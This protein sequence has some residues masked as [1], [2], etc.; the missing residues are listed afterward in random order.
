MQLARIHSSTMQGAIHLSSL[1]Q[2]DEPS[3]MH[4]YL[5]S[6]SALR[7]IV[8]MRIRSIVVTNSEDVLAH[9]AAGP[10]MNL[11]ARMQKTSARQ[12]AGL[13]LI[14][15]P[16]RQA[17]ELAIPG[18][19][20]ARH[21]ACAW[22]GCVRRL[23]GQKGPIVPRHYQPLNSRHAATIAERAHCMRRAPSDSEQVLWVAL[24]ARKLGIG[25]RR[26]YVV[27]KFIA[28]F[29]A[30]SRKVIV[31]VD[32]GYHRNRTKPDAARDEKLR[33]LG[34]QVLRFPAHQVLGD[35]PRVVE[36]IRAA[37]IAP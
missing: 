30:P 37:L 14:A 27:G 22:V 32:G 9:S 10:G 8:V 24:S 28:D 17:P 29:A 34:W 19:T 16:A 33:R 18:T 7:S 12:G 11:D 21:A 2:R 25:F 15:Q 35:L 23:A 26:Q 4:G 1:E 36:G 13:R 5:L 31:E 3:I 6:R 20:C